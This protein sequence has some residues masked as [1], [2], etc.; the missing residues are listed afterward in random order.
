ML[1]ESFTDS[2]RQ[3]DLGIMSVMQRI[4]KN[5]KLKYNNNSRGT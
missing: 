4:K 2:Y 1:Q 3:F 5:F